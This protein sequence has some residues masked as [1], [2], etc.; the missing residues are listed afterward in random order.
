MS[1]NVE[2]PSAKIYQFPRQVAANAGDSRRDGKSAA[3][4]RQQALTSTEFG[5]GWYH[6]A[7]VQA[8]RGRVPIIAQ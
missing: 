8:E 4:S 1:T 3:D 6:D 5:S 2:R 7:A